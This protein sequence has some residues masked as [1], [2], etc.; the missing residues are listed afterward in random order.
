MRKKKK[1]IF[2]LFKTMFSSI[3]ESERKIALAGNDFIPSMNVINNSYES[4][5]EADRFA[6]GDYIVKTDTVETKYDDKVIA[7]DDVVVLEISE[8]DVSGVKTAQLWLGRDDVLTLIRHL[9]T[10]ATLLRD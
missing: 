5:A 8:N 3:L 10:A 2:G 1:N 7:H 6:Y 9:S 4:M